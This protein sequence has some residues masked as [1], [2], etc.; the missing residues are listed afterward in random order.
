MKEKRLV[1]ILA[2]LL[3]I[4]LGAAS[5]LLASGKLTSSLP[6]ES[7]LRNMEVQSDSDEIDAIETDINDTDLEDLDKEVADIKGEIE[8]S[9]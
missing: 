7:S 6:S 3:V 4:V 1:L 5:Y 8:S 2:A 9:E